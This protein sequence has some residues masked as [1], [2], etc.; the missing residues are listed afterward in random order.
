VVQDRCI[1]VSLYPASVQSAFLVVTRSPMTRRPLDNLTSTITDDQFFI[2][3]M[4]N[5]YSSGIA[6]LPWTNLR[7]PRQTPSF[8]VDA[9]IRDLQ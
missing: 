4:L 2:Y 7:F 5:V 8:F 3:S 6:G 9:C 1:G